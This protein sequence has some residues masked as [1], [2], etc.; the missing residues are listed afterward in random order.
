MGRKHDDTLTGASSG[1]V[2]RGGKGDDILTATG[3]PSALQGGAGD[4]LLQNN[5]GGRTS[6]YGDVGD[7][8]MIA[9]LGAID[10]FEFRAG[11]GND[12][13]VGFGAEDV[14]LFRGISAQ[15]VSLTD[16]VEGVLVGYSAGDT[17]LLAGLTVSELT[18]GQIVFI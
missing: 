5:G 12:H 14:L 17:A 15:D 3:G 13:V 9:G 18:E 4:D 8:T 6:F 11:H 16:T 7:D 2:L 10:R 1:S